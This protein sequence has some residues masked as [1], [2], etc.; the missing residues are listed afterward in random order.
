MESYAFSDVEIEDLLNNHAYEM[1]EILSTAYDD[2]Y[3]EL[4]NEG[5]FSE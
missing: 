4:K 5:D 1:A 2:I 3:N